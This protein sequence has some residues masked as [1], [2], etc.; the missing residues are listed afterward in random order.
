M[1]QMLGRIRELQDT[2]VWIQASDACKAKLRTVTRDDVEARITQCI[3]QVWRGGKARG[4]V[5]KQHVEK[6]H[7][8]VGPHLYEHEY[9][10]APPELVLMKGYDDAE[11]SYT[12]SNHEWM[13]HVLYMAELK[14][15]SLMYEV[16]EEFDEEDLR[17]VKEELVYCLFH[18]TSLDRACS[19]Q[20]A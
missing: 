20:T 12:T 8:T 19:T 3:N 9:T 17:D 18:R 1:H 15:Y 7:F 6:L 10:L 4:A 13:S 5:H 14:S 2:E 16:D 11:R